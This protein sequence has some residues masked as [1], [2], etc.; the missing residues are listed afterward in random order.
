MNSNDLTPEERT[1]VLAQVDYFVEILAKRYNIDPMEVV[2]T[3][4]WIKERRETARRIKLA[5]VLSLIGILFSALLLSM[6][7]GL[8]HIIRRSS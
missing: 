4:N 8:L 6:W 7:E 2:E 1:H 5:G 3:V